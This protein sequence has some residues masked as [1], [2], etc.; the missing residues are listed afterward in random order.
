MPGYITDAL[1]KYQ[2]PMPK[3]PQHAPHIWTDSAY[4]QRIQ[5]APS[6]DESPSASKNKITRAQKSMGT[7]L[8]YA[9]VVDPT[10]IVS[11]ITLV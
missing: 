10:L 7:L 6:P 9:C 4:G 5:C 2:H 8:Y 1:H 11:L 3:R